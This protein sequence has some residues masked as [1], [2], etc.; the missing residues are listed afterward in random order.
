MVRPGGSKGNYRSPHHDDKSPSVE[1]R[2]DGKHFIDYSQGAEPDSGSCIDLVMWHDQC[3]FNTA[4]RRLHDLYG[5]DMP[6]RDKPMKPREE[7]TLAEFIGERCSKNAEQALPYLATRGI[8]EAVALAA[9]R[10]GSLGFNTW[11]NPKVA[12]GDF[13]H[14]GE[15][16]AFM[17]RDP[18][19]HAV[20]A[21]D[22][23][24]LKPELNGGVKTQSQGEK[25]GFVWTSCWRRLE[26]AT[27]V[28]V[29]E[30]AINCLSIEV[31]FGPSVAAVAVRGN[32]RVVPLI[33]WS[34]LCGKMVR[35]CG[36]NDEPNKYGVVP[37]REMAWAVHDAVVGLNV[38]CEIV[39][40]HSDGC[41]W[42]V[43][44]VNDVL[45]EDGHIEL[46]A[47]LKRTE[48]WVIPGLSAVPRDGKNRMVLP[49]ADWSLYFEYRTAHDLTRCISKR[50][51]TETGEQITMKDVAGFRVA[52]IVRVKIAGATATMTGSID[53]G[54]NQVFTVACQLPGQIELERK[55][56][57]K[58]RL[59]NLDHWTKFGFIFDKAKFGRMATIL[60]RTAPLGGRNAVNFVGLCWRDGQ[61]ILNE[62]PDTYFTD[63]DKQC[64]F[65]SRLVFPRGTKA[66]GKAVLTAF[67][68]T[69]ANNAALMPVVWLLGSHLKA[70]IGYWPHMQM[71]ADKG[72]GKTTLLEAMQRTLSFQMLSSQS[73]RSEYRQLTSVS[74]TS[75]P[76]G[77]EELST[78]KQ[79]L[80]ESCVQILQESYRYTVTRRGSEMTEYVISAP[81][82]LAGEDV[83]VDSLTSKLV[84]TS[85]NGEDRGIPV[86]NDLHAFPLN[87]WLKWL[88]KQGPDTA[89]D[90]LSSAMAMCQASCLAEEKDNGARRMVENY[91]AMLCAW[92]L[93]SE[94]LGLAANEGPFVTDLIQEMNKHISE[95]KANRQPWVWIMETALSELAAGKFHYPHLVDIWMDKGQNLHEVLIIRTSHIMDHIRHNSH[96]RSVWDSLTVKSDRVFKKQLQQAGIV[97]TDGERKI[98]GTRHGRMAYLSIEKLKEFGLHVPVHEPSPD[99]GTIA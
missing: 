88:V 47:K 37:G 64:P 75:H 16:V 89:R 46:R 41:E 27:T 61:L 18:R 45:K 72:S 74:G 33:D 99:P 25:A 76:I 53:T 11:T 6:S 44:D 86:P 2:K 91:A 66:Q 68:D 98:N 63:P 3:D 15:A 9:M 69:F 50:E 65:Y 14:G 94:W 62:G 4:Y 34:F 60:M 96:L 19:D 49:P 78:A 8:T 48:P 83:P 79:H 38:A 28:Y 39:D 71:Q 23:R 31:A 52:E 10:A 77:W 55:V 42:T 73:M 85:L 30:S 22:M 12:E 20:V 57:T 35:V 95:T 58:E 59:F 24:Y 97:L 32:A 84:R 29:V 26:K 7:Q 81:V 43:N 93:L 82:L 1:V 13:G 17:V 80:I 5:W 67:R 70:M 56:F 51:S 90:R 87:D 54:A 21:V 36:D 40:Q 92:W